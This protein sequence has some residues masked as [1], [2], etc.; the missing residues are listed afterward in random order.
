VTFEYLLRLLWT[1]LAYK[2]LCY[3]WRWRLV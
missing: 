2:S 3:I 1:T